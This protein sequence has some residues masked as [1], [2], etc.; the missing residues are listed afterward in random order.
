MSAFTIERLRSILIAAAITLCWAPMPARAAAPAPCTAKQ[1]HAMD[2]AIGTWTARDA[3]GK[4]VGT[5]VWQPI[6]SGCAIHFTW[7]GHAYNGQANNAYD[8]SRSLWQKAWVSDHGDLELSEGHPVPGR[9][10]YI[11]YD[12]E[13]G[14]RVQMHRENLILLPD[15][16]IQFHYEI[17]TDSGKSWKFAGDAFYTK[18][19]PA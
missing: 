8:A 13:N 10:V 15:G 6:L 2:F 3:K 11:G 19:K 1:Y 5:G 9:M 4:I 16:R 18:V 17:S 7:R 12:Y 14:K